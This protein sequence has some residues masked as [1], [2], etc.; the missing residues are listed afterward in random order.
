[1]GSVASAGAAEKPP[2][3]MRTV[4]LAS[5]AG[6]A[7]EWYDFFIFGTLLPVFRQNFLTELTS[8]N[9]SA[10]LMVAMLIFAIGFLFRP[11]GALIFGWVGDRYGRKSA[12]LITVIMMGG[13]TFAIGLLPTSAQVGPLAA[14]LLLGLRVI[15]GLAVGGEYGGAAIYVAEHAQQH[16]RGQ[17]TAWIQASAAFGLLGA[18]AVIVVTRLALGQQAFDAWG[19]RLP[20]LFSA[21]LVGISIF[22]RLKLSES[23]AFKAMKEEGRQS[24][25][26]LA[27]ALLKWS[28]LKIVLTALFSLMLAQGAIWYCVFFYTQTFLETFTKIDPVVANVIMITAT[29]V[30]IPLYV[31]FGW[32]SDL[33]GRKP[34]IIFGIAL[35]IIA[36]FPS[37]NALATGA[38]PD[39]TDAQNENPVAVH[40][41]PASCSF[42]VDVVGN[43][44]YETPCDI[45]RKLLTDAGVKFVRVDGPAGQ[46]A[47]VTIGDH[48]PLGISS[49][50]GLD[51]AALR[52]LQQKTNRD[53]IAALGDAGYPTKTSAAGVQSIKADTNE[54]KWMHIVSGLLILVV[55]ATALYGPL[56]ATMVELFPTKVRYTALSVPYHI[57]VGWVGGFLPMTAFAIATTTGDIFSGIWYPVG[58]AA[59]SLVCCILFY[60]ETKGR[61]L[62]HD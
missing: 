11:V 56:A 17:S 60:P 50:V 49:G 62:S 59:I 45:A 41:D 43:A 31:F 25:A 14:F 8:N 57:G 1:M 6:T 20:F 3:S 32:L 12:F 39:L 34:V 58:F 18:L 55:A 26:P 38:N 53:L 19:W 37:F 40:A 21:G 46:D 24:R 10:G 36:M 30:S 48:A 28:N 5:S 61:P 29:L 15:Q 2:A 52:A 22:M 51:T 16:K 9:P 42:Q 7:F 13:A 35:A 33:I 23:P 27:E 44:R 4:V 47:T 54:I